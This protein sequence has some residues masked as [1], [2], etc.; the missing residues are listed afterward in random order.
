MNYNS[1]YRPFEAT[2]IEAKD[3]SLSLQTKL[4]DAAQNKY[5]HIA[6]YFIIDKVALQSHKYP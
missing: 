3:N 1:I 5:I 6:T 2:H 4:L